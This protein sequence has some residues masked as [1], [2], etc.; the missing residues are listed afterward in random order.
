MD[1]QS[2]A[3]RRARLQISA[4]GFRRIRLVAP[5]ILAA[6]LFSLVAVLPLVAQQTSRD[7]AAFTSQQAAQG[8][9]EY[10]ANC[11]GCHG[12]NLNGGECA[13]ALA[14]ATFSQNWGG[15]T[16]DTLFTYI[17][18]KMPP[19][20]P[21]SLSAETTADLVALILERNGLEPAATELPTD[22]K[23]LAAMSLPRLATLRSAPM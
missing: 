21:G 19:D 1:M 12:Q 10:L 17:Q 15:K 5:K 13:S 6:A 4:D 2:S 8:R 16:A 3:V 22:A 23:A 7:V 18:T 20:K 14:G 11:A 9:Q